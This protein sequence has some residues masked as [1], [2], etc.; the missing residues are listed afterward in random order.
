MYLWNSIIS[1]SLKFVTTSGSKR[2]QQRKGHMQISKITQD[3]LA[4]QKMKQTSATGNVSRISNVEEGVWMMYCS[5]C[6]NVTKE[7]SK[8][9]KMNQKMEP[10]HVSRMSPFKWQDDREAR[11]RWWNHL[12]NQP[13]SK[14][15]GRGSLGNAHRTVTTCKINKIIN[16]NLYVTDLDQISWL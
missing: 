9:N 4:K 2:L 16:D 6:A 3:L 7:K 5:P 14:Y 1:F 12:G 11:G 15:G 8:N 10:P 13:S